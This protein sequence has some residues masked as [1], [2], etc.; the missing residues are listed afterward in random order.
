MRALFIGSILL[1]AT[2]C[3]KTDP[4]YCPMHAG[5]PGCAPI[6]GDVF[7]GDDMLNIDMAPGIDARSCFGAGTGTV[8]L[9]QPPSG[10]VIFTGAGTL[11]TTTGVSTNPVCLATQPADWVAAGQPEACFIVGTSISINAGAD[12]RVVGNR[13]LVLL[14]STTITINA[15]LDAAGHGVT[16]GP[17]APAPGSLCKPFAAQPVTNTD[18]AGG[19]AGGTFMSQGGAGGDGDD[20]A[21]GGGDPG[22][23]ET[24]NPTLLRAGC[25]GQQGGGGQST[26][27][28]GFGGAGGGAVYLIAGEGITIASGVT[29]NLSGAGGVM[30]GRQGG[31]GGGGSGGMLV[32]YAPSITSTGA[33]L[34]ANGGGGASG[35]DDSGDGNAVPGDD[36]MTPT[37]V[38]AGGTGS[39]TA[40]NGGDGFYEDASAH[41]ATSGANGGS[42]DRGAGG[43]GGGKGWI[44]SNVALS[45]TSSPA[46]VLIP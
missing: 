21:Y 9:S 38:P 36:P 46:P 40:G 29:V 35:G 23:A 41:D 7:P 2:G 11:S 34:M 10:P 43:G 5:A 6:D 4:L 12:L 3:E 15:D 28:G 13:P 19:G 25:N 45:A 30:P 33:F 39:D 42:S 32:L 24:A 37:T 16:P 20:G 8:C 44:Q 22:A 17:G 18:G 1:A 31:G 14:S 27:N 26:T